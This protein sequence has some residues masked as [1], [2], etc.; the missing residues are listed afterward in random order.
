MGVLFANLA[1]TPTTYAKSKYVSISKT[2][3]KSIKSGM[4]YKKVKKIVGGGGKLL[5]ESGSKGDSFHTAIYEWDGASGWGANANVTFQNNKVINKSQIGVDSGSKAKITMKKFKKIHNG[6]SYSK[7]KKIIG[8]AGSKNSES[9]QK[10]S[11]EYT[12]IYGYKGNTLGGNAMF[13]FQGG[14]LLNKAQFGLK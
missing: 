4:S 14:K 9:G 3:F 10:G 6:M 13:T 1:V 7:V 11:P 12:V 5:S 8:G 2:E